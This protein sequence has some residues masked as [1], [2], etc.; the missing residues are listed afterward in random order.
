MSAILVV[1]VLVLLLVVALA[2]GKDRTGRARLLRQAGLGFMIGYGV[3]AALFIIGGTID[4]PGGWAAVGLV[5]AW[6]VPLTA[7]A[8][9]AWLRPGAAV[10][11]LGAGT[12]LA[13]AL[14]VWFA[15]APEA[16]RAFEDGTGPVRA[17]VSFVVA[18]PLGLLGGRR[19][20]AAGAL[21]LTLGVAPVALAGLTDPA[22]AF[23]ATS[24]GV[25]SA[26]SILVGALYLLSAGF[27]GHN[28]G[29]A[30]R[31]PAA[32]ATRAPDAGEA[33]AAGRRGAM[34]PNA[35]RAT[36]AGGRGAT[37]VE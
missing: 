12:A 4:D 25:V 23:A 27:A 36:A 10:G 31:K 9:T 37:R 33:T 13:L 20:L 7:L 5:L 29:D 2:A 11:L 6:A 17:I 22:L 26:P 18:V 1:P 16:W 8:L 34:R 14:G 21:L 28:G 3:L 30:T 15:L 24:L 19:P 32:G 35:G